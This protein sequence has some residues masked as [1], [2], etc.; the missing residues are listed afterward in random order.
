VSALS[1][2]VD[3]VTSVWPIVLH[4]SASASSWHHNVVC[5]TIYITLCTIG[6]LSSSYALVLFALQATRLG[7]SQHH[8]NKYPLAD[9]VKYRN[10]KSNY[11]ND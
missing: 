9:V 1:A 10:Y 2:G 4:E 8:T 11:G 3:G 6:P 5:L 7:Y